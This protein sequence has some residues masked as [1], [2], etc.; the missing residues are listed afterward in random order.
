[1]SPS[2]AIFLHGCTGSEDK[3]DNNSY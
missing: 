3:G 1:M 2:L